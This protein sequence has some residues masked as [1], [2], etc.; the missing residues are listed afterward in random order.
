MIKQGFSPSKVPD[1]LDAVVIGS[2]LGGM[3]TAAILSKAGKKVLVLEQHDQVKEDWKVQKTQKGLSVLAYRR[4]V[5]ATRTSTRV[6]S[7]TLEYITWAN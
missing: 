6:T 7:S 4:A 5:A 1:G 2:G 3:G